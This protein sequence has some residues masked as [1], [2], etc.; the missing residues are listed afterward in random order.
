MFPNRI[1]MGVALAPGTRLLRQ[2]AGA[3]ILFL[4]FTQNVSHI[5]CGSKPISTTANDGYGSW[6]ATQTT[7]VVGGSFT[8]KIATVDVDAHRLAKRMDLELCL[9]K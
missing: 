3:A 1:L 4:I 8:V 6:V 9:G 7:G 5:S 2:T